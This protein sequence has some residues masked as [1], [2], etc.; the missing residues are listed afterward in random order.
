VEA[1]ANEG[2][3]ETRPADEPHQPILEM[4]RAIEVAA[5]FEDSLARG[6]SSSAR[7]TWVAIK[8]ARTSIVISSRNETDPWEIRAP[9][10]GTRPR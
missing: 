1:D 2:F 8:L 4:I 7:R 10:H 6:T 9:S 3:G 5:C